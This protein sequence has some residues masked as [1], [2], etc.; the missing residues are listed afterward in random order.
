MKV[1]LPWNSYGYSDGLNDD[2]TSKVDAVPRQLVFGSGQD[3]C[4][5]FMND[6]WV[7][8]MDDSCK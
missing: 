2:N 3:C 6:E 7:A 1:F 5:L 4:R 8:G